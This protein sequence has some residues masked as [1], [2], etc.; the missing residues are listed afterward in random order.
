LDSAKS[1]SGSSM[2]SD[3]EDESPDSLGSAFYL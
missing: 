1:E 2:E 3:Y